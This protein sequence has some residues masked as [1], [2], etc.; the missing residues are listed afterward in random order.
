[1]GVGRGVV[2]PHFGVLLAQ[3]MRRCENDA[4][5]GRGVAVW[6]PGPGCYRAAAPREAQ[7]SHAGGVFAVDQ[8][9]VPAVL[10]E[11]QQDGGIGDAGAVVRDG[12]GQ[13]DLAG[14]AAADG[15]PDPARAGSASVLQRF[16]ENVR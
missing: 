10:A 8:V 6:S 16:G 9:L 11:R 1:M 15:D 14:G 13:G 2:E 4:P 3:E 5:A 7:E 12:Y